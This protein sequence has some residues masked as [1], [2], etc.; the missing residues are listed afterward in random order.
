L[1]TFTLKRPHQHRF[2]RFFALE[3]LLGLVLLNIDSWF[4]NP[5]SLRQL[6]SWVFLSGS[7][8]LAIHGFWL[9][10]FA[11]SPKGDFED[12]SQSVTIGVYRYIRHP[13]YITFILCSVGAFLKDPS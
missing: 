12:T 11:G 1:L 13:L 10:Y 4:Q 3:S 2:P 7:L 6:T 5:W 8:I 9:L